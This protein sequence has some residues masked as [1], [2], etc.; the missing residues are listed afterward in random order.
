MDDVP[1]NL[2]SVDSDL[3][4]VGSDLSSFAQPLIL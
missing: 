4:S 1:H 2:S 3:L